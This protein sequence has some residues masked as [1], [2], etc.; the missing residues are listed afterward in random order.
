MKWVAVISDIQH[1]CFWTDTPYRGIH[2]HT[3]QL[4]LG[5]SFVMRHYTLGSRLSLCAKQLTNS[6][7]LPSTSILTPC[8]GNGL[9]PNHQAVLAP[10]ETTS[11]WSSLCS[12]NWPFL[13]PP[14]ERC[15]LDGYLLWH[16]PAWRILSGLHW[17]LNVWFSEL[18]TWGLK[19]PKNLR[20][21]QN[22][23]ATL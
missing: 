6:G 17:L 18:K 9:S 1:Q 12:S 8:H 23:N 22:R 4:Q 15:G 20:S 13:P 16:S 5:P 10:G 14:K 7:N 11:C 3:T 19:T 2:S 21:N